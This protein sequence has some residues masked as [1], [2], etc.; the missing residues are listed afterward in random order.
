MSLFWFVFLFCALLLL[1]AAM[2]SRSKCH[3]EKKN[4][5]PNYREFRNND[6]RINV[7]LYLWGGSCSRA[8]WSGVQK[9]RNVAIDVRKILHGAN[10]PVYQPRNKELYGIFSTYACQRY[11][12]TVCILGKDLEKCLLNF[13]PCD[14]LQLCRLL[15]TLFEKKRLKNGVKV[16]S[17]KSA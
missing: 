6:V 3:P 13:N 16:Q 7:S 15:L 11:R 10:F 8:T 1:I 9:L 14:A 4:I 17:M 12:E 2:R 5:C